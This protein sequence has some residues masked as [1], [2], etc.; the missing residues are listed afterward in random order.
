M[1]CRYYKN[2]KF[3][4]LYTELYGY[5]DDTELGKRSSQKVYEILRDNG[6]VLK[7]NGSIFVIQGK[8]MAAQRPRLREFDEMNRKYP[9]LVTYTFIKNT[10][11]TWDTQPNKLYLLSIDNDVLQKALPDQ[12]IINIREEAEI[13]EILRQRELE[14]ERQGLEDTFN[15]P[16]VAL[17]EMARLENTSDQ[18]VFSDLEREDKEIVAKKSLHLKNAFAKSGFE[19]EVVFDPELES[20]GQVDARKTG[21]PITVRFNPDLTREDTAYHEFGHIYID[22]LGIDNPVVAS[23]IKQLRGTSLYARV[24]QNYPEL[25]DASLDKEVLATAIGIEGAK[26]TRKNPSKLQILIN[27]IFREFA[28]LLNSL[29]ITAT[30]SGAATLARELF[31]GDLRTSEMLNPLSA[32]TQK[33]KGE[34]QIEKIVQEVKVKTEAELRAIR[35]MPENTKE[36][37]AI[38]EK[39]LDK[40]E[41]LKASLAKISKIEDLITFV[42]YTAVHVRSLEKQYQDIMDSYSENDIEKNPSILNKMY[43][44]KRDLDALDTIKTIKSVIKE[45]K[46][47][48]EIKKI[49]RP[50]VDVRKLETMEER[51]FEIIEV[52]EGLEY[53]YER[54]IIPMLAD[55]LISYHSNAIDEK[56]QEQIDNIEKNKRWRGVLSFTDPEYKSLKADL[57]SEKITDEEFEEALVRLAV[58]KVKSK[59]IP[60]R[61]ALINELTAGYKDKSGY[62]LYFDPLIYSNDQ[63]IQLFAKLIKTANIKKNEMT[64]DFKAILNEAYTKF[65]AGKDG[66]NVEE[67]NRDIVEVVE[68]VAFR[69]NKKETIKVNSLV[70]PT[71]MPKYRAEEK[72]MHERLA[73]KYGKPLYREFES[74][75]DYRDALAK[76]RKRRATYNQWKNEQDRWYSQNSEP[77]EGWKD[78][79]KSMDKA[80]AKQKA[81]VAS[82]KDSPSATEK[83]KQLAKRKLQLMQKERRDSITDKGTPKGQLAKPIMA[84]YTNP[85]WAAIQADPK[86]KEYYDF[87]LKEFRKGQDLI[88]TSRMYTNPWDTYSYILPSIRKQGIDRVREQGVWKTAKDLFDEATTT[89][90]T[91]DMY[92]KYNSVTGELEKRVPVYYTNLVPAENVSVDVASSLYQFRDMA[93]NFEQKSQVAGTAMV[94][95]DLMLNREVLA[96]GSGG[97]VV[98]NEIASAL[99][100][101]IPQRKKGKSNTVQHLEEFIDAQIFGAHEIKT[102]VGN[103]ELNK[104]ANTLNAYTAL[105]NLSFNFLQAANQT[106]LDNLTNLQEGIAGE[107]YSAEDIAWAKAEYMQQGAGLRDIGKFMPESKLGKAMEFLD[108]LV[109]VTDR[110]GNK[111]VGGK[112]RKASDIGNLM[113]LQS[114]AEHEMA[115]TRMLALLRATKVKDKNGNPIMYEGREA[116]FWDMLVI[117]EKGKMSVDPRVANVNKRDLTL[118]LGGISRRTN[119]TK[120]NV[121]RSLLERRWYGKMFMLFRRY[122]NPGIRRRYG[123]GD[124]IHVDE[125]LGTVTQGMY[126]SFITMIQEAYDQKTVNL[127]GIFDNMN[128]MEQKN[129]KRTAAE[130]GSIV[131]AMA[132]VA[133]LSRLDDDEETWVSNFMLYQAKRYQTEMMQWNP[134]FGYKDIMRIA[135]SPAATVRPLENGLGLV[136]QI[137]FY[138]LPHAVGFPIDPKHVYYQRRTG[139]FNKGDRK[140]RKDIEDMLPIIRGLQKSKTP[141]DAIKW[142]SK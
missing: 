10:G 118:L 21:E 15:D 92:G 65:A 75:D 74:Y 83:Q 28:K 100:M 115:G 55:S 66:S 56:L 62:S 59:Q 103:V 76:W 82:I 120:G 19:I 41:S 102:K 117:D 113:S 35:N 134:V 38:K 107:F 90:D 53:R 61:T 68:V 43:Q 9:G 116:N 17:S 132:I 125:E 11:A 52:S 14:I 123:H 140:V 131:A 50:S 67:F 91:D 114:A 81:K 85:K 141:E 5:I 16:D 89:Q 96:T 25:S 31:S 54:D 79:L 8:S 3:S 40:Q 39:M 104:V 4:K 37:R 94:M 106:I 73:A 44:M 1:G 13:L 88:G 137:A 78:K 34:E 7:D 36:A 58:S 93:H 71:D 130:L 86:L 6:L 98:M 33:S 124:P 135:K 108:A 26:I 105:N 133:A 136:E 18:S 77:I 110:E 122:L 24:A 20:L 23:A 57:E 46:R 27:R 51:I 111:L 87:V 69:D 142:F 32:Y 99:G 72:V 64:L 63:A 49:K 48:G 127:K 70:Q 109:E 30:P 2:G 119:Q 129:I 97:A 126:M 95:R 128:Q 42:E 60:N 29:N 101:K 139:R 22:M 80:I 45:Q 47:V 112:L 84:K 138:D 121:D 12:R